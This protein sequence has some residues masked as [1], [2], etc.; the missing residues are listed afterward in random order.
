MKENQR[1]AATDLRVCQVNSPNRREYQTIIREYCST[2][3]EPLFSAE[4]DYRPPLR[5]YDRPL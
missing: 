1:T 5:S 4:M 2:A 3:L